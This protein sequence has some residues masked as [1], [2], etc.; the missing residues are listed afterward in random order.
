MALDGPASPDRPHFM[1]RLY[2]L[3]FHRT[4][5]LLL[6]EFQDTSRIQFDLLRPLIDDILGSVGEN[7]EGERSI[8]LVGDWKQSIYQWRDAAPDQLQGLHR[9]CPQ[10]RSDR[11]RDAPLQLPLDAAPHRFLQPSGHRALCRDRQ[12]QSSDAAPKPKY[13]YSGPSEV[14]VIPAACGAGDDPAYERLVQTMTQKKAECGCPWGDVAVLCRTNGHMDK[15]AAALAGPTFPPRGSAD[16]NSCRSARGRRSGFRSSP[17]S[18]ATTAPS[19]LEALSTLGYDEALTA[20]VTRLTA[21]IGTA[22]RPHRFT[23]FASAL[24]GLAAPFPARPHRDAL[25]RGGA[26]LRPSRCR[27]CRRLPAAICSTMSHL[28]TVPEGEHADRVKLATIHST[29]GW[30]SPMS[31][32]SGKRDSTGRPRSPSRRRLPLSLTK[33][34]TPFSPPARSREGHPSQRGRQR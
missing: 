12:G 21:T 3:G 23:A 1:A 7:A 16:A 15:V 25:G 4:A 33:D 13:P 17:F 8:F 5:H 2:E 29:K 20:A 9:P 18:P 11:R 27:R 10:E 28:I 6:D 26:L 31:S 22:P 30:N 14:A 34:S 24:R 19:S 32:S